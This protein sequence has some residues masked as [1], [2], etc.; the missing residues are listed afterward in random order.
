MPIGRR[1]W[2]GH[3]WSLKASPRAS[4]ASSLYVFHARSDSIRTRPW[5]GTVEGQTVCTNIDIHP[6]RVVSV[7]GQVVQVPEDADGG[8]DMA[9]L[10]QLLQEHQQHDASRLLIGT[11]SA[12]SNVTG[13]LPDVDAIAK[14]LHSFVCS[15]TSFRTCVPS[16]PSVSLVQSQRDI[17]HFLHRH[18]RKFAELCVTCLRSSS[19]C[20]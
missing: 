1:C 7:S 6:F 16:S 3:G 12:G 2:S 8:V 11:F 20:A 5:Q 9:A 18:R 19:W 15:H 13:V 4:A 17:L 10:P 14:L